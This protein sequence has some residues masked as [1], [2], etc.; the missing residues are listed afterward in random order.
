MRACAVCEGSLEDKRKDARFCS[1]ACR[2][3]VSY[4]R[5]RPERFVFTCAG[6]G[7]PFEA[8]RRDARYCSTP[9]RAKGGQTTLLRVGGIEVD[10]L[11]A[12]ALRSYGL[13]REKWDGRQLKG[14]PDVDPSPWKRTNR[15][16][17]L[18]SGP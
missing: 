14:V 8:K 5:S 18:V 9:C 12:Q 16:L 6:C 17:A 1:S 10:D 7:A 15:H 3:V 4:N 13:W 2:A 11:F